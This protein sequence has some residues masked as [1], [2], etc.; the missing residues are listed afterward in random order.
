MKINKQNYRII[1]IVLL[2]LLNITIINKDFNNTHKQ[3][4]TKEDLEFLKKDI[5]KN[6]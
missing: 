3:Q 4:L 2:A 5:I 1:V 6:E